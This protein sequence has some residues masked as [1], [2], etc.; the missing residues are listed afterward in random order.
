M[1]ARKRISFFFFS[2]LPIIGIIISVIH[3]QS[4]L[5][6]RKDRQTQI[7][8]RFYILS[9]AYSKWYETDGFTCNI[10]QRG[11]GQTSGVLYLP[12]DTK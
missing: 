3:G 5:V 4:R 8:L 6:E 10:S 11:N 12:G 9:Y 1:G 2:S 7:V